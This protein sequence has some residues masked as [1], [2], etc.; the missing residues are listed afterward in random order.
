MKLAYQLSKLAEKDLE[1]IWEYTF[2]NWSRKQADKYLK[3]IF[4]Q[5]NTICSKPEIGKSIF[6][7][8]PE[9]LMLKINTH[10]IIYKVENEIV[11]I[12]R[13]LH[14]RMKMENHF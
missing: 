13:I 5:F 3:Q 9:H 8:K 1:N 10:L 6:D 11:K 4:R 7:V 2:A 14:E 12:D